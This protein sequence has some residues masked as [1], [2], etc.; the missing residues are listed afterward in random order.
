MFLQYFVWGSWFVTMGTYLGQTL[1]FTDTQIGSAYGATAIA[2]I[3]SPF[4]TGIV[5]DRFFASE[6]LLAI[7]HA[8]GAGLMYLM[9]T[10]TTFG[11]FYPLLLAYAFCYMPTL[12]LTNSISLHHVTDS[13]RDFPVIRV[14][15]TVGWIVASGVLVGFVLQADKLALPMQISAAGSAALAVFALLRP[16]THSRPGRGDVME[17]M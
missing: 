6:K 16:H 14:F 13:T 17:S 1:H 5:A 2:A 12:S 3:V 7:L 10:Q 9:S 8:V 4:F 15:G 11:S